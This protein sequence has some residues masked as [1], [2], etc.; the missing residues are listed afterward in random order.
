MILV[1]FRAIDAISNSLITPIVTSLCLMSAREVEN[2]KKQ[3]LHSFKMRLHDS[4][5]FA[6]ICYILSKNLVNTACKSK[7]AKTQPKRYS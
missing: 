7:E 4:L 1:C 6:A 3:E 5:Q 2:E